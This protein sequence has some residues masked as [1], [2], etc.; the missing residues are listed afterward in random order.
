MSVLW[1]F[2][3]SFF[4]VS[5]TNGKVQL[6]SYKIG[7]RS[8][9]LLFSSFFF[10]PMEKCSLMV[11]R[12]DVGRVSFFFQVLFVTNRKMQLDGYKIGCRS[13]ELP[14]FN[15]FFSTYGKVQLDGYK[16]GCQSCELLFQVFFFAT[17]GKVQLDRYKIGC[18]LCEL[19]FS[20]YF[21]QP[22]ENCSLMVTR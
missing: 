18:R 13:C 19:L 3:S 21:F 5:A 8:C 20:S 7:C 11:T 22:M 6:D 9:E 15:V 4:F 2:F 16:I 10:Q 14:F 12:E 17:N 1:A